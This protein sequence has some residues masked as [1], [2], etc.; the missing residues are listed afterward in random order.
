MAINMAIDA[1]AHPGLLELTFD[2]HQSE[3]LQGGD[4]TPSHISTRN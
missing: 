2:S 1:K 3:I 4:I